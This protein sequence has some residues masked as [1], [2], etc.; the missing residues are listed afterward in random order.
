M[1]LYFKY[2]EKILYLFFGGMTT[3]I[4]LLTYYLLTHSI[5]NPEISLDLQIANVTSWV[6]GFLFAFFTNRKYVFDSKNDAKKDFIKFFA[7]RIFTLL[8]DMLIM[9]V[10]VTLLGFKDIIIKLISQVVIV[11]TN[12]ILSKLVVFK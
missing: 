9:F 1:K 6:A 5:L 2:K 10:F 7:S 8:L 11:V 4:S 3:L 12:Y